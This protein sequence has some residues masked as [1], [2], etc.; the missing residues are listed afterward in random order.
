MPEAQGMQRRPSADGPVPPV[1]GVL[2]LGEAGS[3]IAADL[4]AAGAVVRGYDPRVPTPS[5]MVA[6]RDEAEAAQGA[7]VVLSVNSA[8]DAAGALNA[9]ASALRPDALWAD[10]NT[11]SA[12]LKETL[13]ARARA[14]QRELVDI[15][16]MS[17]VPGRGLR[18]PMLASGARAV[19][20]AELMRPLGADVEVVG[21]E[22]GLAATRKL[23]RSVFYKG[24]AV[25]AVEA[26]DAA[27]RAGQEEWLRSHLADEIEAA[28]AATLERLVTGTHRH[29]RR[30]SEEMRAAA[31]LVADLGVSPHISAASAALLDEIVASGAVHTGRRDGGKE[32]R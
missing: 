5:G 7:D 25:A 21:A 28:S 12:R 13:A 10:L 31:E 23:L 3:A 1:V 17:P 30:R 16:L 18:T 8:H 24:M 6:C 2:G 32:G 22:P 20:F 15:A 29:A 4:V 14:A 26:L 19:R 11:G 27:A 9:G